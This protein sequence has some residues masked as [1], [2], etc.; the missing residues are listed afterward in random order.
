MDT[1]ISHVAGGGTVGLLWALCIAIVALTG[2]VG[3]LVKRLLDRQD[4]YVTATAAATAAHAAEL[5]TVNQAASDKIHAMMERMTAGIAAMTS[6]AQALQGVLDA[7]QDTAKLLEYA[8]DRHTPAEP[9]AGGAGGS[10]RHRA[11]R[12]T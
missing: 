10:G 1:G 11:G 9:G 12:P 2:A 7:A 3:W 8:L 5:R 4:A 6:A